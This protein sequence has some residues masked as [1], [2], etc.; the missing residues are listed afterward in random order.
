MTP[1][2]GYPAYDAIFTDYLDRICFTLL[3]LELD[4]LLGKVL[5]CSMEEGEGE[6][7][8]MH[9]GR[10]R[11]LRRCFGSLALVRQNFRAST[12]LNTIRVKAFWK[13]ANRVFWWAWILGDSPVLLAAIGSSTPRPSTLPKAR[14]RCLR[15][16]RIE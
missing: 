11:G 4:G 12:T 10:S 7:E 16:I 2:G 9:Q 6:V 14:P 1:S 5:E 8:K 15:A 13:S 3:E